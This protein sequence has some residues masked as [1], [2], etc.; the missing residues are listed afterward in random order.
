MENERDWLLQRMGASLGEMNQSQ[1][2]AYISLMR[3]SMPQIYSKIVE[4]L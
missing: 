1:R 3:A 2:G 4:T